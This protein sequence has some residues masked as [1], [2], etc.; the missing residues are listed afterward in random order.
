M[1]ERQE[2]NNSF[3]LLLVIPKRNTISSELYPFALGL[4]S[5]SSALKLIGINV[6]NLNLCHHDAPIK[7]TLCDYINRYK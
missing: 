3:N 7:K 2:P 4:P 1:N 5:I 6:F